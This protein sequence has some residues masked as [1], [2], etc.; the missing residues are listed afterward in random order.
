MCC[1]T[2]MFSQVTETHTAVLS[3]TTHSIH[4][5]EIVADAILNITGTMGVCRRTTKHLTKSYKKKVRTTLVANNLSFDYI[6]YVLI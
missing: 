5:P 1:S 3:P 4:Q 6:Y 2:L